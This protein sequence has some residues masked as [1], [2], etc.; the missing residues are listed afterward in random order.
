[1]HARL[2]PPPGPRGRPLIGFLPELQRD[3]LGFYSWL[4]R[5]YG[6]V[7]QY[8]IVS[9]RPVLLS[10]AETIEEVLVR[11]HRE[12]PKARLVWRQLDA[13]FGNGLLTSEGDF[14]MR[15]R[16]LAAPAFHAERIAGYGAVMVAQAERMLER[17]RDGEVRDAHAE[18]M[19]VTMRIAALTLFSADLSGEAR[20][21][22]EAMNSLIAEIGARLVRPVLIPDWIPLPSNVRYRRALTRIDALVHRIIRRRMAEREDRGDLLSML[23]AARDEVGRPMSERQLRDEVITLFMAGHETTAI[24]LSWSW[25]LLSRHPDAERALHRELDDVLGGRAPTPADLPRLRHTERVIMEAMRL[26]PPAWGIG[27]EAASDTEL[28][29]YAVPKGTPIFMLPWIMHRK[30]EFFDGPAEFLPDR[31]AD[32]L[33][34]RLPRFAYMPFGGGPRILH[35]QPIRDDG[36]GAAA[37]HD[38]AAIPVGLGPGP[39][40]PAATLDHA[41]AGGR[42]LGQA[43]GTLTRGRRLTT[44]CVV[45]QERV[46]APRFRGSCHGSVGVGL[47]CPDGRRI[48]DDG[49]RGQTPAWLEGTEGVRGAAG[50]GRLGPGSGRGRV[51]L[52][53]GRGRVGPRIGEGPRIGDAAGRLGYAGY[54]AFPGIRRAAQVRALDSSRIASRSEAPRGRPRLGAGFVPVSERRPDKD[55]AVSVVICSSLEPGRE[56]PSGYRGRSPSPFPSGTTTCTYG[57]PF[58]TT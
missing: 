16:R 24:A 49:G 58:P 36:G 22:G 41:S 54:R 48:G 7:V 13:V 52:R 32:G 4:A 30:A 2:S 51:G 17:W 3:I 14:W 8:R 55:D 45:P 42:R 53:I 28:A 15:Q 6:D 35:W 57:V 47:A 43:A 34:D 19:E 9:V 1:M 11:R 38:R 5:E 18:M 25:W 10:R 27:R 40:R 44:P 50:R 20:G 31:W 56:L 23:L 46:R 21:L 39:P 12:F 33:A 29:G 26:Y 37:R